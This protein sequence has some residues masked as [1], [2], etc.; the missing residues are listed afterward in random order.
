MI[1]IYWRLLLAADGSGVDVVAGQPS[2]VWLGKGGGPGQHDCFL[3][4]NNHCAARP[5]IGNLLGGGEKKLL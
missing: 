5:R 3:F 1:N 4:H 2:A